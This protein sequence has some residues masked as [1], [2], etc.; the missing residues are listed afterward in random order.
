MSVSEAMD[1]QKTMNEI[2][3]LIV[4]ELGISRE[5]LVRRIAQANR[6]R[7]W[8]RG[9][10]NPEIHRHPSNPQYIE[11]LL[12]A[13]IARKQVTCITVECDGLV[14]LLLPSTAKI[15]RIVNA[16]LIATI[17]NPEPALS[18]QE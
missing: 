18:G 15:L 1:Y 4:N 8:G 16:D 13:L 3:A 9:R 10:K 2:Y 11:E 7:V 14:D 5:V 6:P 12:N 17:P